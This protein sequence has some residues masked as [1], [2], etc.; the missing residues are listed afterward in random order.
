VQLFFAFTLKGFDR[1]EEIKKFIP[2][3]RLG[4]YRCQ[5]TIEDAYIYPDT[6]VSL[7]DNYVIGHSHH[8]FKYTQN[9]FVLYNAGSVGQNRKILR[10]GNYLIYDADSGQVEMKTSEY[11]VETLISEMKRRNYPEECMAYYFSKINK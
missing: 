7:D 4:I 2:S 3:Y 9:G 11:S 6:T 5:H 8:Q 1:F 10:N